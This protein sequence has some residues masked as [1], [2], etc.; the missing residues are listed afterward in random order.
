MSYENVATHYQLMLHDD[1]EFIMVYINLH[2]TVSPTFHT[3]INQG[4]TYHY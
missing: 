3:K 4:T 2:T 1:E